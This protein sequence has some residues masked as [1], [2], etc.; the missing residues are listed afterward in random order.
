MNMMSAFRF[1]TIPSA[2]RLLALAF[3]ALASAACE[4]EVM[5]YDGRTGIYFAML[6][7][8][9]TEDNPRYDAAS[10]VPFALTLG[11]TEALFE[12]RVKVIG[13]VADHPRTFEFRTVPE[14]TTAREGHDYELPE[15]ECTV[16]AGEVYGTI[17]IRFFRQAS[18]D[19]CEETLTL[20]LVP[21]RNFSLPLAGWL[22]VNG[23]ETQPVD[24]LR[25][26]I[27]VSDKYV[28]LDGWSDYYYGPYSDKK[29]RLMCRQFS[30]T[31]SD[32]M[33]GALSFVEQV[34]LGQNLRRY[35][36]EQE[37]SGNT[38]YEEY[39]DAEG[40]PVKMVSGDASAD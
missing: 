39:T 12:L 21:N 13:R 30:L 5:T 2:G 11:D 40:R 33:P 10:S 32:F 3:C 16:A 29:I 22:P 23:V 27:T 8:G 38:V 9:S 6:R 18:L 15:G 36:D 24:I 25:H 34:V 20:E 37:R 17:P 14:L 28:R 19:G 4:K 35:L 26:T 7:T 1:H 31:L